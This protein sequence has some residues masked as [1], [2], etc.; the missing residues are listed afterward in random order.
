MSTGG[1]RWA[2]ELYEELATR[3]ARF[4]ERLDGEPGATDMRTRIETFL[5]YEAR[6]LDELQFD[7]WLELLTEDCV[8]WV[9]IDPH[10][11]DAR[12]EVSIHLHDKRRLEDYII[13]LRTGWAHSQIPQ[14]RTSRQIS[15]VEVWGAGDGDSYDV[16]ATFALWEYRRTV[17]TEVPGGREIGLRGFAGAVEYELVHSGNGWL[18]R[19][20]IVRLL[21]SDAAFANPSFLL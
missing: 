7:R 9:P 3:R 16:R 2:G 15:N 4:S 12:R 5:Y 19:D 1:Q 17:G 13:K 11:G 10:G 18:I 14:S 20:K 8:Y 21:N 6:L